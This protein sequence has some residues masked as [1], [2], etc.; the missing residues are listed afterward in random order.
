MYVIIQR[1]KFQTKHGNLDAANVYQ[2]LETSTRPRK[3]RTIK[4]ITTITCQ[5]TA[6]A[7]KV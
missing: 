2:Q 6:R 7:K 1:N 4:P 3:L 5:Q